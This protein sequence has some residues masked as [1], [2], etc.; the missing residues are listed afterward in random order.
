MRLDIRV[1]GWYQLGSMSQASDHPPLCGIGPSDRPL[2]VHLM[3]ICGTGMAALAGLFHERGDVVTG[4]DNGVYPTMSD[5]M[6]S[7]GIEVMQGY[8]AG[9]LE[10]RPDLVVVGNVI[11]RT[12]PEAVALERSGI[13]FISMPEALNRCFAGQRTRIVVAVTHGKTTLSSMIAWVLDT[14]NLEPGFMIGGLPRNF[15]TNH[16]LGTGRFFV[17]EGDE[18]DTA[19]F[20]KQPKFLHYPPYRC[21]HVV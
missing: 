9:N 14:V 6:H 12:N 19:Y 17:I 16:R 21:H 3:G 13:P 4:S 18:Y 7:L 1:P 2:H 8:S 15:R 11:R 20:D 10:P 5:F